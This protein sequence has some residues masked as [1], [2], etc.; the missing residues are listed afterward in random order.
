LIVAFLRALETLA[1]MARANDDGG[2]GACI[3][4]CILSCLAQLVEYF[5][6][7]AYI[8]V[9]V[10]GF[11]Y[12]EAGKNVFELFKNRGW[13]AIIADVSWVTSGSTYTPLRF[14]SP[15]LPS[16]SQQDL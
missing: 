10:Y 1:Q 12:L 11:G 5:N 9:G 14:Y 6:K 16:M 7:W 15:F 13:E 3:A 8:Y 2:I 4:Q